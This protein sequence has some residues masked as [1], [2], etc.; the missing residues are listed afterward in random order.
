MA[1]GVDA[2]AAFEQAADARPLMP[3]HIGAAAR[4]ERDAVAAQQQ[5]ALRQGFKP[6][7]KFFARRRRPA[8]GHA[9]AARRATSS[10]RHSVAPPA[11]GLH[12]AL[13]PFQASPS[14][15]RAIRDRHRAVHDKNHARQRRQSHLAAVRQHV[16]VEPKLGCITVSSF[17]ICAVRRLSCARA[18]V[19]A[20]MAFTPARPVA[21]SHA[22]RP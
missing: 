12:R 11:A 9:A 14:L 1:V 18:R 20:R 10:Q 21:K 15:Q 5:L 22:N 8:C 19:C 17:V 13:S 7:R 6:R 3:V 4:R 16:L 2:D